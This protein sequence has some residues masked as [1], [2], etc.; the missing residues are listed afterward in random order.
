MTKKPQQDSLNDLLR[1]CVA[2]GLCLPHCATWA[3]TGNEVHSPRG[4]LMLLDDLLQDPSSA[5][6]AAFSEAFELCIGCRACEAACPS[7]V[8][9]SLLEHGQ[10]LTSAEVVS[11][12]GLMASLMASLIRRLDSPSLL[13]LMRFSGNAGR[14]FLR[15]TLGKSWRSR[16]EKAPLGMDK[17]VRLL[18]SLPAS[19]V[20]D[21]DLVRHLDRLT[22]LNSAN[23][24]G[25]I[26]SSE[27]HREILFFTG[28]A[29]EGLLPGTSRRLIELLKAARCQVHFAAKQQCC[30]ALAAHTGQ[31]GKASRLKRTNLQ[32]LQPIT[33]SN[34]GD[35]AIPIVVEAAGCG[36]QLKDYGPQ[37]SNRVLDAVVLLDELTLPAM[38]EIPL[39][40]VYHDPCHAWHGQGIHAE[41]RRL[42]EQIPGLV[43]LEPL[44]AEMCCGSGGAWGIHHPEMSEELGRR[45]ARNL[46]ATGADLV[47]TA[48]PGCLGQIQDG[49]ALEAPE[50]PIL[51]L[52]DLIWYACRGTVK[53]KAVRRQPLN[54][55]DES[56]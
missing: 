48:N 36:L 35:A 14:G 7:G 46:S 8:P 44:E 27:N 23:F 52:T 10:R 31:P 50:F 43:L 18:G 30:G 17:L 24:D 3:A 34:E 12:S 33:H 38:R 13:N 32:A 19:P 49:L 25:M 53:K 1:R 21:D 16:L 47:V 39:K 28:C 26:A 22:G 55:P 37:F 29:N 41:P 45:K 6:K 11:Q 9:F 20:Q 15:K 5:N 56:V 51:P 40:V 4:R 54:I 2:C 42:L